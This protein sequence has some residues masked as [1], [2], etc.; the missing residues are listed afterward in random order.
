MSGHNGSVLEGRYS[1]LDA[2]SFLVGV[3]RELAG[4]SVESLQ[5]LDGLNHLVRVAGS[6]LS[7]AVGLREAWPGVPLRNDEGD[8]LCW[9]LDQR[10]AGNE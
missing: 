9:D 3:S 8:L 6:L 1:P 4:F 5:S 10:E 2:G 7:W